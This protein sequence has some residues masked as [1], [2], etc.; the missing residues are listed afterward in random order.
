MLT[1][2]KPKPE[3][4]IDMLMQYEDENLYVRN[5]SV[6]AIFCPFEVGYVLNGRNKME[7]M[8]ELNKIARVKYSVS[9]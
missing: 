9:R 8:S 5:V 4:V 7:N 3:Q 1:K 6:S 2:N